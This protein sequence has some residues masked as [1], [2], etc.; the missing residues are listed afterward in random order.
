M[1]TVASKLAPCILVF[2]S[3]KLDSKSYVPFSTSLNELSTKNL[4]DLRKKLVYRCF[5]GI[6]L[7]SEQKNFRHF[8]MFNSEIKI[9]P[10]SSE[11]C[12]HRKTQWNVFGSFKFFKSFFT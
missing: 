6:F 4:I 3:K 11:E 5:P 10:P 1:G 2:L 7:K 12:S 8:L 9:G